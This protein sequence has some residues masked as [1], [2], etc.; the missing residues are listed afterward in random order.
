MIINS[1][2]VKL[3]EINSVVPIGNTDNCRVTFKSG[4]HAVLS[5]YMEIME[6]L[7]DIEAKL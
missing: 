4:E 3:E 2:Y 6:A 7:L 5:G 1:Q